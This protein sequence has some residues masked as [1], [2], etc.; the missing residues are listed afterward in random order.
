MTI[1]LTSFVVFPNTK[2]LAGIY[3][4]YKSNL[5]LARN[6]RNVPVPIPFKPSLRVI[7]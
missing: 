6:S 7:W 1:F 4:V 3:F 2:N 5:H